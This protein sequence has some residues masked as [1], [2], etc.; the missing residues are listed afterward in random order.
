[1]GGDGKDGKKQGPSREQKTLFPEWIEV[2]SARNGKRNR[3][4]WKEGGTF[5]KHKGKRRDF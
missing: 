3:K 2:E 1:L 5:M 4:A